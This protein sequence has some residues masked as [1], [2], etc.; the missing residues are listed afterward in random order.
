MSTYNYREVLNQIQH[1]T[2][3]EQFQLLE[4]LVALVRRQTRTHPQHS[5]MELKGL[6]KDVWSGIDAQEYVN[7][8]RESWSGLN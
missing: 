6:G 4:D 7:Q 3:D 2:P 1:L 8:E 5:I